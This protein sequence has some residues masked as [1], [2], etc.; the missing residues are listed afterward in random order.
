MENGSAAE[1]SLGTSLQDSLSSS[2][3]GPARSLLERH[4]KGSRGDTGRFR[5]RV[6]WVFSSISLGTR[7]R[8]FGPI[9][10]PEEEC[11]KRTTLNFGGY[12][13]EEEVSLSSLTGHLLGVWTCWSSLGTYLS[14][15]NGELDREGVKWMGYNGKSR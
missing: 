1:E 7:G 2:R 12:L 5:E 11:S 14:R 9:L 10:K 3:T 8:C 13:Q 15:A 6:L 4:L